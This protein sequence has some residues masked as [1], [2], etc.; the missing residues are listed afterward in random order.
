MLLN[1]VDPEKWYSV[2]ESVRFFGWGVDTIRDWIYEGLLQAFIKPGCSGRR[3]R[4]YRGARIQGCEIIR[5]VKEHLT[6]LNPNKK[7]RFRR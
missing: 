5:F 3:I 4:I 6:E 2:K 1:S 7:L